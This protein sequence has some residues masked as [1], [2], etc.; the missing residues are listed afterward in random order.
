LKVGE[1]RAFELEAVVD[2]G[3]AVGRRHE[4][5][6]DAFGLG[7]GLQLLDDRKL[8]PPLALALLRIIIGDARADLG[9]HERANLVAPLGLCRAQ[10]EIHGR[11]TISNAS[12]WL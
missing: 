3:R 6:P 1:S 5:I 4:K 10:R 12:P 2:G 11:A 7:L 9:V 8:F